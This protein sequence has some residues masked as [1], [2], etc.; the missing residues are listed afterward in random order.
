MKDDL[1]RE[2]Q[3]S[4]RKAHTMQLACYSCK[5]RKFLKKDCSHTIA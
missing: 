4:T 1:R 3:V 5:P 2:T